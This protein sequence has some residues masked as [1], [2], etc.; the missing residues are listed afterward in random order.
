MRF[1]LVKLMDEEDYSRFDEIYA[2]AEN[3]VGK[4]YVFE[5]GNKLH[6]FQVKR[7]DSGPWITYHVHD[8]PGVPRKLVMHVE[9][10]RENFGHLFGDTY[11]DDE[12]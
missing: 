12:F 8:G 11:Y 9:E 2:W 6:V 10:F 7:R 4:S 5:D 1:I 3:I